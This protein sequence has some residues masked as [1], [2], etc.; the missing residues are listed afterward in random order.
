MTSRIHR[1]RPRSTSRSS[2]RL[3]LL[4]W[5]RAYRLCSSRPKSFHLR[6]SIVQPASSSRDYTRPRSSALSRP[7]PPHTLRAH[8]WVTSRAPAGGTN[9]RK[10][11]V[12]RACGRCRPARLD[13][14]R[15]HGGNPAQRP[16]SQKTALFG[17]LLP[18]LQL[19]SMDC[20][21]IRRSVDMP[22][23]RSLQ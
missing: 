2:R 20:C 14:S 11:A 22:R 6:A 8:L 3:Y 12:R 23:H 10:N 1:S 4:A 16:C 13:D 9:G 7:Q 18:S 15:G 5:T 17:S 21:S 19:L